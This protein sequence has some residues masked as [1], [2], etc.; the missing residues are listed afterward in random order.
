VCPCHDHDG[1]RMKSPGV[2]ESGSPSTIVQPP[3]SSI[4]NLRA[5]IE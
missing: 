3:P 5:A 4:T 2:I 1:V